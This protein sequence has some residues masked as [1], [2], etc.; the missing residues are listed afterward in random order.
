MKFLVKSQRI[1]TERGCLSG[2]FLVEDGT[3]RAIYADENLPDTQGIQIRDYG[4]QRIIPGIIEMH[5][6]GYKGWHAMSPDKE[7]IKKLGRALTTC[8]VTAFLPI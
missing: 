4:R 2:A 1:Y 3:I 8:G 7:E 6:H 5:V